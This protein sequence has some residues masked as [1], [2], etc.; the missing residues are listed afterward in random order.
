MTVVLLWLQRLCSCRCHLWYRML[1]QGGRQ[2]R[3]HLPAQGCA[4]CPTV[5]QQH[6]CRLLSWLHVMPCMNAAAQRSMLRLTASPTYSASGRTKP[7]RGQMCFLA[8]K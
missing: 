5:S 6:A 8:W 1:L 7:A 4:W 3:Q 2:Q